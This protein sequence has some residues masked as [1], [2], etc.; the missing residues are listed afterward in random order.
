MSEHPPPITTSRAP[1]TSY[2]PAD[3]AGTLSSVMGEYPGEYPCEARSYGRRPVCRDRHPFSP[4]LWSKTGTLWDPFSPELWPSGR[5]PR[6]PFSPVMGAARYPP[7]IQRSRVWATPGIQRSRAPATRCPP[8]M[9]PLRTAHLAPST[10]PE[11]LPPPP[12]VL[13]TEH[14]AP[15]FHT[16][17][18]LPAAPVKTV[19]ALPV[20]LVSA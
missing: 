15:F 17:H 9:P 13:S 1:A 5:Y 18:P 7:G 10:A 6:N 19:A 4:E 3:S 20:L 16:E 14:C 2:P 12:A 11:V 8:P